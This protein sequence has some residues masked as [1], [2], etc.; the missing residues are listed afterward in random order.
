MKA[1]CRT[2]YGPPEILSIKEVEQPIPKEKEVLVK[3]Y[4]TTVNRT[5]CSLLTGKPFLI[6]FISGLRKPN[7][8]IPGTDFAGLVAQLGS[9]V[10]GFKVGDRVWG[11]D[12]EGLQSNAEYLTI[13]ENKG[14]AK[15]PESFSFVEAVSCG[16][17]A[18]YAINFLNKIKLKPSSRVL[19]NGATG[20]IGSALVQLL[21]TKNLYVAAVGN[22]KNQE[23]LKSLGADKF[24][25]Y[26]KN[27]FT[28]DEETY[29]FIFDAVGKSR[30][31]DCKTL[32]NKHGVYMSSELGKGIEN[33]YLPLLTKFRNK[34]VK[35]P[36]PSNCRRS[37]LDLSELMS[38]GQFKAVIDKIYTPEEIGS[39]YSYVMSGQKT[40]NVILQMSV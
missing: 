39:A 30:F 38:A 5:D 21:K 14:I 2:I 25:D 29:D 18:H 32:L 22:T 6:R 40:G 17:G 16:E 37:I 4:A 35:F 10:K 36:F 1:I 24:I 3:V 31:R 13:A 23:L 28:K 12:D 11:F 27:D 19:V 8:E 20:A 33:A 7:L 15:I 9:N 26:E 34:K